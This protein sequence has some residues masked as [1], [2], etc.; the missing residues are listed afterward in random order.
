MEHSYPSAL[1][2]FVFVLLHTIHTST[3][4]LLCSW[5][6]T[7]PNIH[8]SVQLVFFFL[9]FSAT[10]HPFM[11]LPWPLGCV[12]TPSSS[13]MQLNRALLSLTTANLQVNKRDWSMLADLQVSLIFWSLFLYQSWKSVSLCILFY[14]LIICSVCQ[15]C[16]CKVK[17]NCSGVKNFKIPLEVWWNGVK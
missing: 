13:N 5:L 17:G 2:S 10:L 12:M 6:T 16:T 3:L 15:I 1:F 11:L 4:T 7:T 9:W 14:K 8:F